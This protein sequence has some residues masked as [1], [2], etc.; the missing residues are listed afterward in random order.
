LGGTYDIY[1]VDKFLPKEK[2]WILN[3]KREP[4]AKQSGGSG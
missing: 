4:K 3:K 1:N 2:K